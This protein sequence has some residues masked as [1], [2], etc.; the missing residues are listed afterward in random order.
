MS[1]KVPLETGK[2]LTISKQLLTSNY[3]ND[4]VYINKCLTELNTL[5]YEELMGSPNDVSKKP[6]QL[7]F[8]F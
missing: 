4:K 5:N 6:Q 7:Q 8:I 2:F 3:Y 1:N